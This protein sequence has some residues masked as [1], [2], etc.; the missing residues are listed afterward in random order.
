MHPEVN[1]CFPLIVILLIKT[2]LYT[3][4]S[5]R[6]NTL[7]IYFYRNRDLVMGQSVGNFLWLNSYYIINNRFSF[8]KIK[9]ILRDYTRSSISNRIDWFWLTG[10]IQGNGSF[11]ISNIR[12]EYILYISQNISDIQL[13]YKIKSF[14][15]YGYIRLQHKENMAHYIL[16]KKEGLVFLLPKLMPFLGNKKISYSSF[17]NKYSIKPF[18]SDLNNFYPFITLNNSWLAGFIDADG[19]FYGSYTKNKRMLSGYQLQLRFSITQKNLDV[20]KPIAFI[21]NIKVRYNK[22]GFYYFILSD[23]LSL[24]RLVIYIKK[25]PLFSKKS[26]S[27]TNWLKLY[28]LYKNKEHLNLNP[29]YLK[30]AVALINNH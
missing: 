7:V 22:K 27:F 14:I 10:F 2:S 16:Q 29:I 8:I 17:L 30:K 12:Q 9:R 19:S 24:D 21:F 18:Y 3:G 5:W 13:L 28:T 25:F 20:L 23:Q 11:V 26:I 4:N 1:V 15:G 6:L